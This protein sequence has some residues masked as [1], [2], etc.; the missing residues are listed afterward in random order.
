MDMM[1]KGIC[2]VLAIMSVYMWGLI[3]AKLAYMS[4]IE[5][6]NK[7]MADRLRAFQA[8]YARDYLQLFRDMPVNSALRPH[9]RRGCRGMREAD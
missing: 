5:R 6:G 8:Q 1:G 7:R 9:S 2:I 4:A 3:F